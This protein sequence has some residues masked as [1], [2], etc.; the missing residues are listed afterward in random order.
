MPPPFLVAVLVKDLLK[1]HIDKQQ[2]ECLSSGGHES[3]P[4]EQIENRKI[5][6]LTIGGMGTLELKNKISS[7]NITTEL[8]GQ[9]QN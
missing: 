2:D 7:D 1:D 6:R 3:I 9:H 8:K 5:R 4:A